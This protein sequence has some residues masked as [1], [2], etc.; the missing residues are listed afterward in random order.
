MRHPNATHTFFR[1][2]AH[3]SSSTNHLRRHGM[4]RPKQATPRLERPPQISPSPKQSEHQRYQRRSVSTYEI[5]RPSATIKNNRFGQTPPPFRCPRPSPTPR[6]HTTKRHTVC[7]RSLR[8]ALVPPSAAYPTTNASS[9]HYQSQSRS[10]LHRQIL[11]QDEQTAR[12]RGR[13][14]SR[15][16]RPKRRTGTTRFRNSTNPA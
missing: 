5:H 13:S 7:S 1:S 9:P 8:A 6:P 15:R 12:G 4:P 10:H 11:A 3:T 2:P 14:C 16:N